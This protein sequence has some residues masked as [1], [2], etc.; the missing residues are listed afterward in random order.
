MQW[1]GC[2]CALLVL[3]VFGLGSARLVS[4]QAETP[5]AIDQV[6]TDQWIEEAQR[7]KS[8]QG[9]ETGKEGFFATVP[10]RL[11][12]S[13]GVDFS[14][15]DFGGST[16]TNVLYLPFALKFDFDY[17]LLKLTVPYLRIAGDVVSVGGQAEFVSG[18]E[19][20]RDG[21]GDIVL[22]AAYVY[23]PKWKYV[24]LVE[25]GGKIKFGTASE[26]KGLGTGKIDY[27]LQ[28]DLSKTFGRFTPFAA[29]GYKFVGSPKGFDLDNK[30]FVYG[31]IS[32]KVFDFLNVGIVYDWS[33]SAVPENGDFNEISPFATIKVS[34]WFAFDPYVVIG[35]SKWSPDWGIGV[36]LRFIYDRA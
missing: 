19:G 15:G 18:V 21:L 17:V 36:Q 20:E 6:T 28:L 3:T 14:T 34:R 4:A 22:A 35:L 10:F 11:T 1:W 26:D 24:P 27:T 12:A 25:V 31:G 16:D 2:L 32:A 13:T 30:A 9:E 8:Q 23:Y 29:G 7:K 5:E 33:Q